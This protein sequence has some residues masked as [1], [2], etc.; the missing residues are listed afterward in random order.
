MEGIADFEKWVG[1]MRSE[2]VQQVGTARRL[3]VT[4]VE[5]NMRLIRHDQ[6]SRLEIL[7]SRI[8]KEV[9]GVEQ[10][11]SAAQIGHTKGT[12]LNSGLTFA[13][14]SLFMN[15]IGHKDSLKIGAQMAGSAL[16][17]KVPF[18]TVL[19]GIGKEGIPEDVRV[20]PVSRLARESK[21]SET[22]IEANLKRDGYLL[23][24]PEMFTRALDR[25]EREILNGTLS[26]P[27][28]INK[29]TKRITR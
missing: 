4:F 23:M 18:G 28:K 17:R 24:A 5:S 15:A 19:I 26:L 16:S 11:E 21:R 2:L 7:K 27:I 25:V 12:L 13:L 14:G 6:V 9:E 3:A 8:N 10:M 1:E 22:D 29:L 20:I